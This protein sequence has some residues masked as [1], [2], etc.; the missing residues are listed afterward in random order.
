MVC[1]AGRCPYK[2]DSGVYEAYFDQQV[3]HGLPVFRGGMRGRGLG[4]VLGGLARNVI[5]L[6]KSG[7]KTLLKE[8]VETGKLLVGDVLSGQNI[9]TAIKRRAT[10]AGKRLFQQAIGQIVRAAPPGQPAAPKRRRIKT[11]APRRRAQTKKRRGQRQAL[12][13]IFS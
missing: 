6:L 8:G 13:D 7:G 9:K 10:D 5:P 2:G 12:L 3:G 4:N 11:A 1:G